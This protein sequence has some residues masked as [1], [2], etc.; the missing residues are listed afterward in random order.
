MWLAMSSFLQKV[1]KVSYACQEVILVSFRIDQNSIST[2]KY[3]TISFDGSD[4]LRSKFSDKEIVLINK[5]RLGNT[6]LLSILQK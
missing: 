3:E 2:G 5:N 4:L 6:S 1:F